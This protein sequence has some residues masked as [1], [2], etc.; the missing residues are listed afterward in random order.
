MVSMIVSRRVTLALAPYT[1]G[2]ALVLILLDAEHR[3]IVAPIA[4][5]LGTVL[6][7]AAKLWD[8]DGEMPIADAGFLCAIASCL[9]AVV[10]LL[11]YIAGGLSFTI[12]SDSRLYRHQ[13]TP[14]EL[15]GFVLRHT[16]YLLCLAVSYVYVRGRAPGFRKSIRLPDRAT[17]QSLFV[18]LVVC[19]VIAV[20]YRSMTGVAAGETY[21]DRVAASAQA[22]VPLVLRQVYGRIQDVSGLIKLAIVVIL[23]YRAKRLGWRIALISWLMVE[24]VL[25]VVRLG[26]RGETVILLMAAGLLYHRL[27]SPFRLRL[28]LP[29]GTALLLFFLACGVVR[30]LGQSR[31]GLVDGNVRMLSFN[32]EFQAVF[33]TS[34]DVYTMVRSGELEVP[35]QIYFNDVIS[36]L[37]PQQIV[38]FEKVRAADW[39]VKVLGVEDTGVGYM[40][41]VISQAIIGLDWFEL[42]LRGCLLGFVLAKAHRWYARHSSGFYANLFYI[43]LCVHSYYTFRDTTFSIFSRALIV[44][45]MM[46]IAIHCVR[47]PI[48][49]YSRVAEREKGLPSSSDQPSSI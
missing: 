12:L 43:W 8:A 16:L 31:L 19:S 48:I 14:C 24:S 6:W 39:Y 15:G 42:V 1:A 9:Y 38:G 37:P 47:G 5:M 13:P 2:A 45:I 27:V 11:N 30:D 40:W 49:L 21:A 35:W 17:R 25:S 33:A 18:L 23:V 20:L 10:P 22:Q 46:L 44:I 34:Y 28:A 41:G 26:S 7:M 4:I 3:W 32:N 36:L 29:I